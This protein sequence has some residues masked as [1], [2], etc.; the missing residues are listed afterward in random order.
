MEASNLAREFHGIRLYVHPLHAM[1]TLFCVMSGGDPA[2]VGP[3]GSSEQEA[4]RRWN[5]LMNK[6]HFDA[7]TTS[8]T[9]RYAA[10]EII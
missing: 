1:S 5:D 3:T 7:G 10:Q 6:P 4:I 9:A 2:I 8:S